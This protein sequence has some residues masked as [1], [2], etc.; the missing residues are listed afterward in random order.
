VIARPGGS[1]EGN[2]NFNRK[3]FKR[4]LP[5]GKREVPSLP[6]RKRKGTG[7][8]KNHPSTIHTRTQDEGKAGDENKSTSADAGRNIRSHVGER[9]E[10]QKKFGGR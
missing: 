7:Y 1:E 4:G 9:I 6:T 3:H 8:K 2:V 10:K 5:R